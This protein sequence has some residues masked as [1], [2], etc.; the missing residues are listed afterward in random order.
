MNAVDEIKGVSLDS[1]K[2]R[3]KRYYY[4]SE[5]ETEAEERDFAKHVLDFCADQQAQVRNC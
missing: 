4:R 3:G 1:D 2:M 5:T